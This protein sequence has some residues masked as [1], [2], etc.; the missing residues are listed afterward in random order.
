M[1]RPGNLSSLNLLRAF[2]AA[3]RLGAVLAGLPG[4]EEERLAAYGMHVGT[5]FQ[6][7]DDVLDYS[8]NAADIG[9]N[10]G[11]VGEEIGIHVA[12]RIDPGRPWSRRGGNRVT[13]AQ[14]AARIVSLAPH[15]TE[16]LFAIGAVDQN[17]RNLPA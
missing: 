2:E 8:G 15:L 6:L 9:K 4:E 13:L 3:A 1:T 10:V 5:A 7:I 14:P 11:D 12:T 16:Q 17:S